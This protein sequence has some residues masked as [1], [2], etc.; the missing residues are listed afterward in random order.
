L[1]NKT[2]IVTYDQARFTLDAD[3]RKCWSF[4]GTTP[5]VYKNGSKKRI[6]IGGA[7]SSTGE[8]HY[9]KMKWQNKEQVLWS[10]KLMRMK[11]PLMFLLLDKAT[12]NKNKAVMGYLEKNNIPYMFFPAGAS[13]LNPTESC[14]KLTRENVAANTSHNSEKELFDNLKSF[15]EEQPFKHNML[16]Y[17]CP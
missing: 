10:I 2:V 13:D 9:Y 4:K 11:F 5:I 3:I 8:F 17:L 12:W 15:W 1:G 16:N 14:W 6:S 7:Y